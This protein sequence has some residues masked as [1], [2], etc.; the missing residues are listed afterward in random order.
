MLIRCDLPSFSSSF[1]AATR[2]D[3]SS[4][5]TVTVP[6]IAEATSSFRYGTKHLSGD[7]SAAGGT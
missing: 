7:D 3:E 2:R 5:A 6:Q 1:C 4:N